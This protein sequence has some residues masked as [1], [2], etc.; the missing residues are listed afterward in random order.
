M[1]F[2]LAGGGVPGGLIYSVTDRNATYVTD[3]SHSPAEFACTI[4]FYA[5]GDISRPGSSWSDQN[6]P[7]LH[8]A[9]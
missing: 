3:R 2:M 1:S 5:L 4:C 8:T 9:R 6:P 7:A